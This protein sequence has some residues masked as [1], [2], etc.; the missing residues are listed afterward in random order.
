MKEGLKILE[1]V[2]AKY[3]DGNLAL[4]PMNSFRY[5]LIMLLI[6][7]EPKTVEDQVEV[8]S[9]LSQQL[10]AMC[11][12]AAK[13]NSEIAKVFLTSAHEIEMAHLTER[14]NYG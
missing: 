1:E 13:G 11:Y 8:I 6:D 7:Q 14:G 2:I 10:A 12:A 3:P 9:D 4:M 5:K